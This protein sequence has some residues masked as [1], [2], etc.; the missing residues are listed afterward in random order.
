MCL[1]YGTDEAPPLHPVEDI[2]IT[3]SSKQ[4]G[5]DYKVLNR[6]KSLI[7]YLG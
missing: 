3:R 7:Q 5:P 6:P 2:K 1:Y 4:G